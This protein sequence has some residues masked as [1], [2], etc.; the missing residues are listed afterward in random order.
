VGSALYALLKS[1]F[2]TPGFLSKFRRYFA[3]RSADLFSFFFFFSVIAISA[4]VIFSIY[5]KSIIEK[6]QQLHPPISLADSTEFYAEMEPIAKISSSTIRISG[7]AADSVII[8]L[9]VNGKI[10]AVSL[11]QNGEF[12]FENVPLAYGDN[13]IQVFA[14]TMDGKVRVLQRMTTHY[15]APLPAFLARNIIRGET[16]RKQIAL[17]FD[18]GSGDACAEQILDILKQKNIRCTL[19]L[20]GG[21]IKRYPQLVIRM[22]QEGHEIGNHT[23]S[24]PHLTTYEQ[25][26]QQHTCPGITRERLQ[27]ELMRTADLFFKVTR[28]KMAPLWRA[29][30]GE[31]NADIRRWAAEIGYLQI[32]WTTGGGQT[33]D[34]LDWVADSTSTIYH[35]TDEI[36]RRLLKFGQDETDG[37]NGGIILMH[38]DTQR[39]T[40][41]AYKILPTLIDSMRTKGYTFATI[42]DIIRP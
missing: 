18:G 17:T 8:S 3:A 36:L 22:V 2:T 1:P 37:A 4:L 33:M 31:Q 6:E 10:I 42:S 40:D 39:L 9:K 12:I 7:E 11:P 19:F 13:D 20:T 15:G 14:L 16:K 35:P 29:P 25:D 26:Q 41:P 23:W 27:Q 30:F 32:G 24:H 28:R 34:S 38:L 21:F 5:K